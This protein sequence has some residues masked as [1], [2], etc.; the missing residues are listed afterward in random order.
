MNHLLKTFL[1]IQSLTEMC[2]CSLMKVMIFKLRDIKISPTTFV[3]LIEPTLV[4]DDFEMNE[5]DL[6][7]EEFYLFAIR[8]YQTSNFNFKARKSNNCRLSN[9]NK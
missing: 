1:T 9:S 3:K 6:S 5:F 8:S 4:I 7:I 2:V